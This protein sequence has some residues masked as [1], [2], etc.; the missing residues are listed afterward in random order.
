MPERRQPMKT[1]VMSQAWLSV[2]V[3]NMVSTLART[4]R[5]AIMGWW[6]DFAELAGKRIL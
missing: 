1:I 6:R 4:L 3:V 5:L 2:V